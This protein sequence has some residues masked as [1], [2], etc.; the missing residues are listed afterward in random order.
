MDAPAPELFSGY[1][2]VFRSV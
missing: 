2:P 1:V